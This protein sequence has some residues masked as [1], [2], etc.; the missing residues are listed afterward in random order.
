[1]E[2][3]K[4]IISENANQDHRPSNSFTKVTSRSRKEIAPVG[5]DSEP[6]KPHLCVF[7]RRDFH[8]RLI[9]MSRVHVGQSYVQV[10][11]VAVEF[12]ALFL[13]TV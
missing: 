8:L 3:T 4:Q 13:S 10:R 2:V 6:A 5:P 11:K 1:M 9:P 12:F 7:P